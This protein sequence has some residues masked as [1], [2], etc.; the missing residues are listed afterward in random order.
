MYTICSLSAILA[1]SRSLHTNL[2]AFALEKVLY[3]LLTKRRYAII[4]VK[5]KRCRE[6]DRPWL[7]QYMANN[8]A[9]DF[10]SRVRQAGIK[11]EG[12]ALTVHTLRKCC[13]QTWQMRYLGIR[14]S[15]AQLGRATAF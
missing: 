3:V 6:T 9:S 8:V 11:T 1:L 7:N 14:G 2:D 12:K 15:V 10:H 13:C 4:L 5:W